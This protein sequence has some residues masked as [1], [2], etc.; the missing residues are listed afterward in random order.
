MKVTELN[1]DQL[2][3]LRVDIMEKRGLPICWLNIVD[4]SET[5]S[6]EEVFREFE[7]YNFTDEDFGL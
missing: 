4:A 2:N 7:G 1:R 6:D 3:V 5:I